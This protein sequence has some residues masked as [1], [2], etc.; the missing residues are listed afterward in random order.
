MVLTDNDT[1]NALIYKHILI[2]IKFGRFENHENKLEI[3]TTN[4][5]MLIFL[6]MNFMH[7]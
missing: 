2:R 1:Y 7:D 4:H 5:G 6:H 3:M